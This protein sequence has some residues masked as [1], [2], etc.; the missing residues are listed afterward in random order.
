MRRAMVVVQVALSLVLLTTGGLVVRS[1]ERLLRADPGFNPEGLLTLRVPIPQQFHQEIA[2]AMAL[3]ERIELELA[4]IPGVVSVSAV[5]ALPLSLGTNQRGIEIPG[6]PGNTG[7]REKDNV[8]TD[9]FGARAGY[10]EIMGMR[11]LEGRTFERTRHEG[12]REAVIDRVLAQRFFPSGGAV[13]ATIPFGD[14]QRLTVVGIVD[15]ARMYDVHQDGRPQVFTRAE[16]WGYRT[17]VFVLR[18]SRDPG[19]VVSEARG[20]IRK[21]DSRLAVSEVRTMEEVVGD[22]LRQQ[23]ISA[24]LVAGFAV[25][26]LLLAAMGLFGVVSGAVTRRRHELA[27]RLALGA[28]H[29]RVLWLV[30]MEGAAL[31]GIGMLIGI[32]GVIAAGGLIRG[33]LVGVSPSDPLTLATVAAA[34]GLVALAAC[35]LPA[36]RVLSLDPAQSL[37]QP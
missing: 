25:G 9:V 2:S 6:A 8:L 17:V 20:A 30:L 24:V 29:P 1:F 34:L 36:R 18:T 13:G 27:V 31:V 12:V 14:Q 10:F 33:A 26:A 37:R 5:N 7:D 4:A 11:L 3:Q 23:R 19:G 21:L 16:D 28:D 22:S 35:Y 15:Q 32:P